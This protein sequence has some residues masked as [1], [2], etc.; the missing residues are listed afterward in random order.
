MRPVRGGR[1]RF[2]VT[3]AARHRF[4]GE[5]LAPAYLRK[6]FCW[7]REVSTVTSKPLGAEYR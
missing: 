3:E 6:A 5:A 4:P 2:S 1:A 7:R